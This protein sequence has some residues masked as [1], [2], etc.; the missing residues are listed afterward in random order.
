M[1]EM[2]DI[3]II[4]GGIMGCTIASQIS[5]LDKNKKI[6]LFDKSKLFSGCSSYAGSI[7][8]PINLSSLHRITTEYSKMWYKS[9]Q[10]KSNN[11]LIRDLPACIICKEDSLIQLQN[12]IFSTS[13]LQKEYTLPNWL[14]IPSNFISNYAM[15]SYVAPY[16]VLNQLINLMST[17]DIYECTPINHYR[18]NGNDLQLNLSDGR[19]KM[20][21]NLIFAQGSWLNK[22]ELK[23]HSIRT[24]KIVSY[25]IDL[26]VTK[27]DILIY[28]YEE[29]AFLLP[30]LE[31]NKWF[32]S[33][34]SDD[35]DCKPDTPDMVVTA[36]NRKLVEQILSTYCHTLVPKLLGSSVHCD[37]YLEEC[38]PNIFN[39]GQNI[40]SVAGASGSGFRYAPALSQKVIKILN[41]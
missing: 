12:K 8:S 24:K 5:I 21:K 19:I 17:V 20:C 40:I 11:C 15:A 6:A 36:K 25:I 23:K 38:I 37:S 22:E 4:G 3:C 2:Y 31:K 7:I 29:K 26:P 28:F 33:I 32:I 27:S 9:H 39:T 10:E 41:I 30:I 34:T 18:V 16:A 13:F 1:S 35:W 14:H